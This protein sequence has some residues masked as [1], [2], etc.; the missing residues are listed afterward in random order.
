MK[1][2]MPRVVVNCQNYMFSDMIRRTL[3]T[4]DFQVTVVEDPT[5]VITEFN[6][7]AANIVLL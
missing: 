7:T 4:G 6:K 1:N 5:S 2:K 3:R